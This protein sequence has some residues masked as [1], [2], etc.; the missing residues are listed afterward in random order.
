MRRARPGRNLAVTSP[1][2][3]R[4]QRPPDALNA[5][6]RIAGQRMLPN[7]NHAPAG[8]TQAEHHVPIPR[9]VRRQL[10]PPKPFARPQCRRA[11]GFA[12]RHGRHRTFPQ[13]TGRRRM[14][15]TP[16]PETTVH[17]H[18]HP[19]PGKNEIRS[20]PENPN[21]RLRNPNLKMPSPSRQPRP[22]QQPRQR[23][24]RIP[25]AA[26]PNPR[27]HRRALGHGEHAGPGAHPPARKSRRERRSLTI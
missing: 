21:S 3:A 26:R 22:T 13:P 24:L 16:M 18:R 7:P 4:L 14:E 10:L 27:H 2:I 1:L 9:H 20:H 17:K 23:Q 5:S 6:R 11:L 15:R 8:P 19:L 25:V 12:A